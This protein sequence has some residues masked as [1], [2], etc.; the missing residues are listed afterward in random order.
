MRRWGTAA[1]HVTF[2]D[3][4]KAGRNPG[5]IIARILRAFADAQPDRHVRIVG[6]PIWPRPHRRRIAACVQHEALI[7]TRLRRTRRHHSLPLRRCRAPS[8]RTLTDA[9]ATHPVLWEDSEQRRSGEFDW[10]AILGRYNQRLPEPEAAATIAVETAHDLA[11]ARSFAA[12]H[13]TA[14][15]L[16]PGRVRDLGLIVTELVTNSL[17]HTDGP[18]ELRIWVE[19][20]HLVREVCDRGCVDDPLVGRCPAAPGQLGGRG[21]LVVNDLADLGRTRFTPHGT[22]IRALL[23]GLARNFGD[24]SRSCGQAARGGASCVAMRSSR[25]CRSFLVNFH[26]NGVAICP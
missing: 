23:S 14:R 13:A 5:C 10:A 15:G 22:T 24:V 11:P 6:E 9:E 20:D 12:E 16:A 2:I 18:A 1:D 3:M 17:V 4:A 19:R 7:N 26:S 8:P 21:L 25:W